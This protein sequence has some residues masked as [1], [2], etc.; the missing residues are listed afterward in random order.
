MLTYVEVDNNKYLATITGR[1]NDREWNNRESKAI[2]VEMAY[3]DA[4]NI[5]VD[6]VS[7]NIVQEYEELVEQINENGETVFVST[8]K[9]ET[10]DNSDY[11]IA[12]DIVNHRDGTITVKMGKPTAEELLALFE[13]VL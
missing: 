4:V 9:T 3:E 12:G 11:S 13:E 10:Y 7:W 8:T 2:T 6:D 1:L 5:F